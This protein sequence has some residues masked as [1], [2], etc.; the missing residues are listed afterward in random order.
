MEQEHQRC[1]RSGR[2]FC[3]GVLDI[4]QFKAVNDSHGRGV[5]D[6]VLRS[7]AHEA[8]R[9][10]RVSD[11]LCALERRPLRAAAGRCPRAAGASGGRGA[12]AQW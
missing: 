10:V 12:R 1:I 2:T 9:R 8:M 6:A 5:G 3:L 7:V 11:A 4:D